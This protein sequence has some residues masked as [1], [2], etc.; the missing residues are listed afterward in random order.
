MVAGENRA[1]RARD[2]HCPVQPPK[3]IGRVIKRHKNIPVH[4]ATE[5]LINEISEIPPFRIRQRVCHAFKKGKINIT[6]LFL[7]RNGAAIIKKEK[8]LTHATVLSFIGIA[9]NAFQV[10]RRE[11]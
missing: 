5:L 4:T 10:R 11:T 6:L 8:Q 1:E 2:V 9:S 3:G 7:K